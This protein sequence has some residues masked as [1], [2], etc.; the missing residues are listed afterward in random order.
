MSAVEDE[1]LADFYD[2]LAASDLISGPMLQSLRAHLDLDSKP[3][4]DALG[5][6]FATE[7]RDEQRDEA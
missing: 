2:R 7:A 3:D 4:P 6:I 1:I 5:L